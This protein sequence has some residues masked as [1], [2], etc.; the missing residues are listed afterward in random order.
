MMKKNIAKSFV[1][2][3]V[4]AVAMF[5][6]GYAMVPLYDLLC[7]ITGLGGK[8]GQVSTVQAQE[9][10]IDTSRTVIVEFSS[11]TS[12]DIPWNFAPE[13]KRIEVH[14][15]QSYVINYK[16]ENR[17]SLDVVGQAIPSVTPPTASKY[18]NK[19]E[20][21]CFTQQVMLAKEK[22][23]MPVKFVIDPNLPEGI[24]T[25]TLSYT[26]F[27]SEQFASK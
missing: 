12:V 14:P 6:F 8:T 24:N 11:T 21:F 2:L 16:A 3:I 19:T 15:G 4:T 5:G 26:F 9:Y 25:V 27:N 18:F 13:V 17:S 22:K 23:D 20:C 10:G 7:D 1:K